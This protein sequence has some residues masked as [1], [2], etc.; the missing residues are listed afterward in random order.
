MIPWYFAELESRM[1]ALFSH[2]FLYK[3]FVSDYEM[4]FGGQLWFIS[5]IIQFYIVFYRYA[6][7]IKNKMEFK[8]V[9]LDWYV[10]KCSMVDNTF[11]T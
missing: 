8:N 9:F 10:Y 6:I 5:T 1:G 7:Y 11:N 3:M 2:I 4:S